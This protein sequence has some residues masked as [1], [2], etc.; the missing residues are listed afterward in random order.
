MAKVRKTKRDWDHL[1]GKA[2]DLP[3]G[4]SGDQS[5]RDKVAGR[6]AEYAEKTLRELIALHKA[7]EETEAKIK[8][9]QSE[10]NVEF[11]ALEAL[12]KP[13]FIKENVRSLEAEDG[14]ILYLKVEPY[15]SVFDALKFEKYL[16]GPEGVGL[17]A[18]KTVPWSKLNANV[19]L[20]I[21]EEGADPDEPLPGVK[22]FL[23]TTVHSR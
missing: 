7:A 8:K 15:A 10:S 6:R 22:V 18:Q 5:F 23:K 11:E 4:H 1:R 3:A 19:K 20:L 9:E 2:K 13:Y 16:N 21:S 17:A 14:R 12:L